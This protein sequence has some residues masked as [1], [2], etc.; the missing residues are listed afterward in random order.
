MDEWKI[1]SSTSPCLR[2]SFSIPFQSIPVLTGVP[3]SPPTALRDKAAQLV[4][5][6]LGSNMTP[7]IT[8]SDDADRV[9]A[10]LERYAFGG[11]L[12]F[13]GRFP[14][15]ADRLAELQAR[16]P[17]PLLVAADIERG[18]GQQVEGAT[19]F[20]HAM[21]FGA[22]G[23]DAAPGIEAFAR[24][25]A[26]EALACG[27]HQAFA[28]VADVNLHP[29][30]PIISIRAFGTGPADV[31]RHVE[32]YLRGSRAEGLITTAKHFPGHGRTALDTHATLPTVEV[33]EATLRQTDLVPFQTAIAAGVDTVMTT[34][35]AFPALD[36]E[37]RPATLS[38]PILR[39]LLRR[40]MQFEGPIVTDSLLM[41]A[42]RATHD[43]PGEQAVA[44][45][46]AGVDCVLDPTEPEAVVEGLVR[47]VEAGRL[48]AERIDAAFERVW[49]LKTQ[50]ARRFGPDLFTAPD[51]YVARAEVGAA[52][53]RALARSVAERAVTVLEAEPDL[54]PLDPGAL[55][56]GDLAVVYVTP[57]VR[58]SDAA[59]APLGDAVRAAVPGARYDEVDAG[60]RTEALAALAGR[61]ARA[62][63][64]VLVLAV[65][66]AAWRDFG[67]Q[68]AQAS[69]VARVTQQASAI[70]VAL[71][72]PHVL[73]AVPRAAA[74]LCT[75]SDVVVSQHALAA[76]LLHG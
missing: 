45:L 38:P 71:G 65:T 33:S 6:R 50:L 58:P 27:I 42:V 39:G 2:P 7:P 1:F 15:T 51:R 56:E 53:H 59:E 48:P 54:L 22:L 10:L 75:Y 13:N 43:D 47:A 29:H 5:V 3:P 17:Y 20:P 68:P 60:T 62:K 55:G 34:H 37:A 69:F 72:S 35:A 70:V 49:Q 76:H 8:A 12:L 14:D 41:A 21:A 44:L 25:T 57:R 18:V 9:T 36:P 26:R 46:E 67:L 63:H 64:I 30:N 61:A 16:S 11:L 74:R 19:L 24:A 23:E 73:E 28:P 52:A 31:T 66:P 4:F 40:R 32:A